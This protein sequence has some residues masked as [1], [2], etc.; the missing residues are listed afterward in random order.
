MYNTMI[1]LNVLRKGP[2]ELWENFYNIKMFCTR[3]PLELFWLEMQQ[4]K[5][6]N[7]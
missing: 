2:V 6:Q 3:L 4:E 5:E 1:V 7:N